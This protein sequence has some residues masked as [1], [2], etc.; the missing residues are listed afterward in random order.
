MSS[1]LAFGLAFGLFSDRI[2]TALA[3][4][5]SPFADIPP[6][7]GV[8]YS[9]EPGDAKVLR[10]EDVTF[11]V[12]VERGD[13][14]RLQLEILPDG[15][16]RP[17]KYD[18]EKVE[19]ALWRFTLSGFETSF[20][21]RVR[22]GGTW[23]RRMRMT[24]VD[25]PSIVGLSTILH[26]PEYMGM[27][28]PRH[29]VP[30]VADVTGP[31]GSTVEIDVESQ[32]DVATGEI[33][34][35]GTRPVRVAM[36]ERPERIWFQERLPDGAGT[37]G[38]WDWD[39]RLLAR[40]AHTEPLAAGV[41]GHRFAGCPGALRGPA[42]RVFVRLRVHRSQ[43]QARG[44]HGF[45]ARWQGLGSI[46]PAGATTSSPRA[47]LA[48]LV[49][50][51]SVSCRR[52]V[53][54]YGWKCLP[55][56]LTWRAR[57]SGGMGFALS[58]GRCFW[59]RAGALPSTHFE[60]QEI[61]V[62]ATLPMKPAGPN[63]WVGGFP[64]ERDTLY[65][66]ELKNE[67]G[68]PSKPMKEAKATAIVDEPPQVVLDRPGSDLV[69]STPV[70]V[71][72]SIAAYDDFGLAD[73]VVSVQRGDQGGFIGRP[74]RHFDHPERSGNFTASLDVP[75]WNLKPGEQHSLPGGG[76]RPQG[77]GADPR[78]RHPDRR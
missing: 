68:H 30:Q 18:L 65:R 62:A 23:T 39:F 15:K 1:I 17:L 42:R 38:T 13:P 45:V 74:V 14:D 16:G 75:A 58:G 12:K 33:Q 31:V 11:R 7:S 53:S 49:A 36:V 3:R 69:L 60:R 22:G 29:G 20:H 47:S 76:P 4:I 19:P 26:Y 67:L 37:E 71:P 55:G 63:R 61:Y 27:P 52:P 57:R 70:K 59:H 46:A 32:G 28:E 40:P 48:R 10:G 64:L 6:A 56:R 50:C 34:L 41:H 8:L 9:V 72:L 54:G 25:R 51:G 66:V 5:F 24:V 77:P 73:L 78:I 35:L 21:Y 43:E 44:D 2:P